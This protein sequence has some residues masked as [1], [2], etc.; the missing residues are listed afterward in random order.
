MVGVIA[1]AARLAV[2]CVALAIA[3]GCQHEDVETKERLRDISVTLAALERKVDAL[4][5]GAMSAAAPPT[6]AAAPVR[7]E[8]AAVYSVPI[9]GD[10][11]LGPPTARVTLVE[12][13]EF[14]CPF[15]RRAAATIDEL[16]KQYGTDLRVVWKHFVH[17]PQ[18]ATPAALAGCAAGRQ[19]KFFELERK[20]WDQG[21]ENDAIKDLSE[22]ALID[23][24]RELGLDTERFK[25]DMQGDRCKQL[26]VRDTAELAAVG[27]RGTP[28]FFINGR[29]LS[30]AQP[31]ERFRAV[32]DE[33]LA[34]AE[35]AIRAG[36]RPEDLYAG[37]V[38][39]G[40]KSL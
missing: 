30:G 15:S 1:R 13:G 10:P 4:D 5:C 40:R 34:R 38:A 26:V 25:A 7:P 32:I 3:A 31:I 22:P 11:V 8:P 19:G 9:D 33:E 24:A 2:A 27:Q 36:R 35:A 28:G 17:H 21:W 6:S 37:I 12:G 39:S 16:R 18:V 20:I 23:F 14:D 29:F